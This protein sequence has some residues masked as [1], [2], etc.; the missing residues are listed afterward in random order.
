MVLFGAYMSLCFESVPTTADA[1]W[2]DT[3]LDTEAR[4]EDLLQHMTL[5]EKIG[6]MALVEKNSLANIGDVAQ[7]G[8]GG[9]LSGAGAKPATNTVSGWSTMTTEFKEAAL[10]SRLGIPILY[11]VDAVHG[12]SLVPGV[13][14][15]PH[16]IGLGAAGDADLVYKIAQVTARDLQATGVNWN[17]APNLDLPQDMRWGRVY[18]A[19]SDDPVLVSRL[20][21]AYV[22]GLQSQ[23][24]AG[25]TS[26]SGVLATLKH[27]VGLGAMQWNTSANKNFMIDQAVTPVDSLALQT[28]YLPP[29][30]AGIDAGALS[31]M[32][33]LNTWDGK[34][35]ITNHDLITIALKERL[36][37]SGFVVSDWYGVYEGR[38]S[39]FLA[40]VQAINA[41]VDMVMLPFDYQTFVRQMVVANRLGLISIK[42]IDDAV[43]RI[44]RAKFVAGVFDDSTLPRAAV[45]VDESAL[46]RSA[47]A[48]SL[49]LL[50]NEHAAL[51]LG[52][53]ARHIRV[54]G[55]A[56]DNVGLQSGAWTVEWQG[57]DGNWLPGGTSILAGIRARAPQTTRLEYAASGTFPGQTIAD[58]GIAVVGETPYAEGWGDRLLP[59]LSA[60]DL[61]VI[62]ALRLSCKKVVVVMVSGRPLLIEH[63]LDKIDALVAAWLPG[64]AGGGVADVLFGGQNFKGTLPLS[65]P[66]TA[67]QL[68]LTLSGETAD[69]TAVLFPRYF[70]LSY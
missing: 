14:V 70:G 64:T 41:G 63:E 54:A 44:L 60:N 45:V 18:E 16:Q 36:G 68:P 10:Q 40:T 20:A 32:V 42:R 35:L 56:A 13:T 6:Q 57:V 58:V 52:F 12:H 17:F 26:V 33:G 61:A 24:R 15:F 62:A 37:F 48:Q 7:Y 34:R 22:A 53:A 30:D 39:Q 51:P 25:T 29:F 11:G 46:A 59:T 21:A 38:R 67:E 31:V 49:V 28:K 55:S 66:K 1:R 27:Y 50:K 69:G 9:I 47:V 2:L 3:T 23:T 65:W 4:V 8:L 19:Y 5:R 43:A